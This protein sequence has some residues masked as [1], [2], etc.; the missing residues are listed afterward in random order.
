MA[1]A[2]SFF[3]R[4][5][6]QI[7]CIK[8]KT[9]QINAS[10]NFILIALYIILPGAQIS[11][12]CPLCIFEI[13]PCDAVR[14]NPTGISK[15]FRTCSAN[16]TV[17]GRRE[18]LRR[19]HVGKRADEAGW[20]RG[21]TWNAS[22]PEPCPKGENVCPETFRGSASTGRSSHNSECWSDASRTWA[23]WSARPAGCH[24][25]SAC[26]PPAR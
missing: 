9:R 16:R 11:D 6:P 13:P 10:K 4:R 25:P 3:E 14:M 26:R 15:L 18:L 5:Y 7:L 23:S 2:L 21:I 17:W 24:R 1:A 22:R 19:L 12:R 8:V 20:R